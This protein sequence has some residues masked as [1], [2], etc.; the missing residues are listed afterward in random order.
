M[1]FWNYLGEFA[2]F[3]MVC[4]WFSGQPKRQSQPYQL[5][6]DYAHDAECGTRIEE[7][8]REIEHSKA[9]ITEY[10][11]IID[12]DRVYGIDDA[13]VD[14]LQD[15]IDKLEEQLDS[16][17]AM[18]NR[19]YRIQDEIDRLQD[20]LDDIEERQDMYDDLQYEL[21]D[22]YDDLDDAEMDCDDDW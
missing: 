3:N 8:Q 20:C 22:L 5:F 19:Y 18:S 9:K 12:S 21:D 15:R 13:D 10:Q 1:S 2:L 11:R 4:N 16:C 14:Q 7:L 17:D 6:H